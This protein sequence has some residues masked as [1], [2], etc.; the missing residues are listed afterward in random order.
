[1]DII[2]KNTNELLYPELRLMQFLK[3]TN[4]MLEIRLFYNSFT[5]EIMSLPNKF[6]DGDFSYVIVLKVQD[7]DQKNSDFLYYPINVKNKVFRINSDKSSY[8][9]NFNSKPGDLIIKKSLENANKMFKSK[10]SDIVYKKLVSSDWPRLKIEIMEL[11]REF[12]DIEGTT[13]E[14][15]IEFYENR[16]KDKDMIGYIAEKDGKYIGFALGTSIKNIRN[17]FIDENGKALYFT[18]KINP[19]SFYVDLVQVNANYV[20]KGL[21]KTLVK[22][23]VQEAIN[24][25]YK[26]ISGHLSPIAVKCIQNYNIPK[27]DLCIDFFESGRDYVFTE[28]AIE[29]VMKL[30]NSKIEIF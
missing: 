25:G 10:K 14:E 23:L 11:D 29:D 19:K 24:K 22:L 8:E 16:F 13:E 7:K 5:G 21:G 6:K 20:K 12:R 3:V 18:N 15:E 17:E 26:T 2:D 28:V 4:K 1:M 30:L 27:S 9:E